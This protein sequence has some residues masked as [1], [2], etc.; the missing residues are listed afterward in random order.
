V[1]AELAPYERV[2]KIAV[3]DRDFDIGLGEVTPTLKV[4]RN[5]V[6]QKYAGL[7]ESLYK[8]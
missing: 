2:K 6:E 3:L 5:I 7:I 1:T 4:K 8:D